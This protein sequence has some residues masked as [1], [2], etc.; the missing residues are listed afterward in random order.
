M[1][2]YTYV[3]LQVVYYRQYFGSD[4]PVGMC[5]SIYSCTFYSIDLGIR[6]GGGIADSIDLLELDD[7]NYYTKLIFGLS[8]F[9]LITIVSMNIIFGIIIDTFSELRDA[10]NTRTDDT[11]NVCFIS[12]YERD[13]FEKM[14]KSFDKHISHFHNP[15]NY[16]N[17]LIY[18]R[19]KPEDLY[20]GIEAYVADQYAN[21]KTTWAPIENT[22]YLKV[23][24][25]E[26]DFDTKADN[27]Q[28]KLNEETSIMKEGVDTMNS[29][30]EELE[31]DIRK[32]VSLK[33]SQV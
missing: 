18:I 6:N 26:I 8:Y 27:L 23:D 22:M 30:L 10:E 14:G 21:K 33:T 1:F 29:K 32:M 16:I 19:S 12:G 4:Y 5:Y 25:D 20:D 3:I 28:E 13:V 9:M 17:F 31:V 11:K 15:L 2:V 7:P 24:K